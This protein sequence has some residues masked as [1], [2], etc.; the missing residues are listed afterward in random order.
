MNTLDIIQQLKNINPTLSKGGKSNNASKIVSLK[1]GEEGLVIELAN[2]EELSDKIKSEFVTEEEVIEIV[3]QYKEDNKLS[4]TNDFFDLLNKQVDSRQ[5]TNKKQVIDLL[6]KYYLEQSK[7]TTKEVTDMVVKHITESGNNQLKDSD[8]LAVAEMINKSVNDYKKENTKKV[9]E[10]YTKI[11]KRTDADSIRKELE[12]LYS[13]KGLD[14]KFI[15][16]LEEYIKGLNLSKGNADVIRN[17]S[18]KFL[19]ALKDVDLSGLDVVDG[20]YVLASGGGNIDG[21]TASSIYTT[22]QVVDGGGA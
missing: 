16:N 8:I 19:S 4:S 21:G 5:L 1:I 12:A 2:G 14:V 11:S 18:T 3:D 10:I 6:E 20:K 13:K 17:S 7:V 15:H 22:P 9:E